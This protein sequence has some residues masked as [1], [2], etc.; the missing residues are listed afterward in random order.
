MSPFET[1]ISRF[2]MMTFVTYV[3][4]R[5]NGSSLVFFNR[6]HERTLF[7][8]N[9]ILAFHGFIVSIMQF[10]LPLSIFHTLVISGQVFIF[11]AN[12]LLKGVKITK[13]Q[14]IGV[15][16]SFAGLIMIIN[17]RFF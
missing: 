11:L 7:C 17:G 16:I 13:N 6:P 10:Y 14:M 2:T 9:I 5:M 12:Y 1:T 4:C 8:R 15:A 3:H